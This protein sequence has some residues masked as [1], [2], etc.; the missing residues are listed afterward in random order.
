M[1]TE[2]PAPN[3]SGPAVSLSPL[4]HDHSDMRLLSM[5]RKLRP[6]LGVAASILFA[7]CGDTSGRD[8]AKPP[9][10]AADSQA[11]HVAAV[12]AAGGVVDSILPIA[13]HLSR[14]RAS[15]ARVDTLAGAS[16]SIDDLVARWARAVAGRDTIALSRMIL[17]PAEF[18]WL[19]YPDARMAKPPYEAPPGLLWSQ[20]DA[21][22]R[23]GTARVLAKFGGR[24]LRV[25]S[26]RCP[27]PIETEGGNRIRQNCVVSVEQDGAAA[28]AARYFGSIIERDGRFKFI[29]LAN[30]L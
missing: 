18:A 12:V 28:P 1:P 17:S 6:F 9:A 22:G 5:S 7:A 14:F 30:A 16:A 11:A 10:T 24:P 19:Y 29:S 27:D 13:E 8:A 2:R 21:S 20:I 26:V 3:D 23:E 25:R 15:V 4:T